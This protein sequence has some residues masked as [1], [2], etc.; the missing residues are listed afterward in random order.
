MTKVEAGKNSIVIVS[1]SLTNSN[2]NT[3]PSCIERA[4]PSRDELSL[5]FEDS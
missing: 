3:T 4:T 1:H 5:V 2:R